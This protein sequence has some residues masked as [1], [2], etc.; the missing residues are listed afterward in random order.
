ML[1]Q[2]FLDLIQMLLIWFECVI[3]SKANYSREYAFAICLGSAL[4][5]CV[6]LFNI[7]RD[8]LPPASCGI[9]VLVRRRKIIGVSRA[10]SVPL[11]L[12]IGITS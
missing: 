2:N 4:I 8:I 7:Y 10:G 5:V 12:L 1:V 9:T 11:Q 3:C 6:C